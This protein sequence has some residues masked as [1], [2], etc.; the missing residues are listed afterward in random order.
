MVEDALYSTAPSILQIR[1]NNWDFILGV[2][3]DSR[4]YLFRLLDLGRLTGSLV[5]TLTYKQGKERYQ[6]WFFNDE[7]ING[8]NLSVK[9]NFVY[10]EQSSSQGK[11]TTFPG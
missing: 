6:F 1:A 9:V 10:C 4:K 5:Q 2:K 3:P 8:S 11:L 7:S